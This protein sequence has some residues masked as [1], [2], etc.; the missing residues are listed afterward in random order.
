MQITQYDEGKKVPIVPSVK[1]ILQLFESLGRKFTTNA[2]EYSGYSKDPKMH[3][4]ISKL[5]LHPSIKGSMVAVT[6]HPG[7]EVRIKFGEKLIT[8]VKVCDGVVSEEADIEL[9]K[10]IALTVDEHVYGTKYEYMI[11]QPIDGNSNVHYVD[12]YENDPSNPK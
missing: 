4:Y 8:Q 1:L 7:F 9:I 2:P 6:K 10:R 3:Y 5:H 11:I 12:F